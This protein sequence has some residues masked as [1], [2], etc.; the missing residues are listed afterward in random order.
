MEAYPGSQ[1]MAR[2]L[3]ALGHQVRI[4]PAQLVKPYVK[5]N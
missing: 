4:V 5:S 1:W 2:K 3:Q